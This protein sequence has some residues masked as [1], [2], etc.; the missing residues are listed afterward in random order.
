MMVISLFP[1][2]LTPSLNGDSWLALSSGHFSEEQG[3]QQCVWT[4]LRAVDVMTKTNS[5]NPSGV[6]VPV[7][8]H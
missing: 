5:P 6:F 4:H 2:I 7:I 1:L 3:S 8:S